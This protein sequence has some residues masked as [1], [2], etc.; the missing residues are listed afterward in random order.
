MRSKMW[1]FCPGTII[2]SLRFLLLSFSDLM[3]RRSRWWWRRLCPTWS[4]T[5]GQWNSSASV[6]PGTIRTAM[7]THPWQRRKPGSWSKPQVKHHWNHKRRWDRS[8]KS[9]IRKPR[10]NVS[11]ISTCCKCDWCVLE[12]IPVDRYPVQD[13]HTKGQFTVSNRCKHAC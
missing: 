3:S 1:S 13:T 11:I 6:T 10:I 5:P 9:R 4:F 2:H 8:G 12:P 7:R